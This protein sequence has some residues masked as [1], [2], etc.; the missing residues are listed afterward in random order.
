MAGLLAGVQ[1][2][3]LLIL[4]CILLVLVGIRRYSMGCFSLCQYLLIRVMFLCMYAFL[5][6]LF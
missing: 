6:H 1:A 2:S 5:L 4:V 3:E